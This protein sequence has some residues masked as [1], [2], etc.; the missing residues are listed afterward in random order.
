MR[1]AN[2]L[3]PKII[4]PD[5][6]RLA[7]WKARKGLNGHP[8][9]IAYRQ[10]L[11]DNL[12]QLA[13]EIDTGL[14]DV[15]HYTFFKIFDPKERDICA[16]SFK[17][18]VLHHAIMNICHPYFEKRQI[19]RSYA[20]R[21][22]KGTYAALHQA[23]AYVKKNEWYLKLDIKKFFASLHH[24]VMN[25]QLSALFK[26]EKL[27]SIFARIVESYEASPNRGVPLGNL[28]SQ[29]L[30]NHYLSG[31]DH[32]I[33]EELQVKAYLRY[34]DDFVLWHDQK[35]VLIACFKVIEQFVND[36]LKV[37]LKPFSLNQTKYGINFLGY[38]VFPHF[39]Y[40]TQ[41]SKKRYFKK[42]SHIHRQYLS[43]KWDQGMAQR[44]ARPVIAFVDHA[45][46]LAL[47]QSFWEKNLK[48]NSSGQS[49]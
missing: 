28:T 27:L 36:Q 10:N 29:Y 14:V 31:L 32:L 7:F 41:R 20:C 49:S 16:S 30:G 17:E 40:L 35:A 46:T 4:E 37:E 11:D 23:K 45:D 47:K 48:F 12:S 5:N 38:K 18:Q 13:E 25:R 24:E 33:K 2:H 1:R 15:G 34:M 39:T 6:L 3:I 8:K 21:L 42:M 44:H 9:V 19:Y 26:D 22:N 43:E